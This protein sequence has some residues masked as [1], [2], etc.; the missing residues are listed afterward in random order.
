MKI[1]V[2]SINRILVIQFDRFERYTILA[3]GKE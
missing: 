1:V 2:I 3:H